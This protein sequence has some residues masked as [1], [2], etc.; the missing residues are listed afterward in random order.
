MDKNKS[1][2]LVKVNGNNYDIGKQVGEH[3]KERIQKALKECNQFKEFQK[4]DEER[5]ERINQVE[6][7]AKKHFPQYIKEIQGISDG[8]GIEY[9]DILIANFRHVPPKDEVG[10]NCSSLFFINDDEIILAHNEDFESIMG[11]YSYFSIMELENGTKIFSHCY[12]GCIPGISFGFNNHGITITSNSLPNPVKRIGLSRILFGRAMLESKTL[13]EAIEK[14]QS[15]SP[16]SGGVSYNI[17]SL[18]EKVA[19]NLETTADESCLTEITDKYFHTNHH[20]SIKFK[21]IPLPRISDSKSR[22]K[23]G[24]K[25]LPNLEKTEENALKLLWDKYIF[26]NSIKGPETGYI[27]ST[28]Y[29]AIF[30]INN[31]IHLKLYP[32]NREKNEYMNVSLSDLH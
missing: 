2:P 14:A 26:F 20:I 27:F 23:R 13:K 7:L 8:C 11:K 9:R 24:I 6:S 17:V 29:T 5:P 19:I 10:N 16:R 3:F 30:N 32:H 31:T 22:Y 25:L 1:F 15:F 28:I 4:L 21:D 18:N 12:P